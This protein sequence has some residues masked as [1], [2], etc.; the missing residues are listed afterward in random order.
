MGFQQAGMSKYI[1]KIKMSLVVVLFSSGTLN[2]ESLE[3]KINIFM[4]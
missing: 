2:I 4:S 1:W 3:S